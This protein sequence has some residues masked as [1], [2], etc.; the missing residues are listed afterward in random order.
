[1]R[2]ENVKLSH[3]TILQKNKKHNACRNYKKTGCYPVQ[4]LHCIKILVD[5]EKTAGNEKCGQRKGTYHN[6]PGED[7]AWGM[8]FQKTDKHKG[9]EHREADG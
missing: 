8:G 5:A 1:M 9:D 2:C 7:V 4:N 3:S 6:H